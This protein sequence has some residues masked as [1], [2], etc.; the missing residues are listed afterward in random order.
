MKIVLCGGLGEAPKQVL[1]Y[2]S[3]REDVDELAVCTHKDNKYTTG[4]TYTCEYLKVWYTAESINTVAL[5]FMPDVIASVYYKH[6]IKGHVIDMVGGKIINAHAALLPRHRGRSA[7]PWAIIERDTFSGVTYHYIDPGID[8]GPIILQAAVL[9][10]K[11]ETQASLFEKV[12]AAVVGFFPAALELVQAGFAGVEQSEGGNYNRGGPPYDGQLS[13]EWPLNKIE[14][15]IRA[16][17]YPPYPPAQFNG[18]DI[19]TID[20]Y[21]K[22]LYERWRERKAR[23]HSIPV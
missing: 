20:D 2:L 11:Q 14:R 3:K 12:D 6:I 18:A 9:I 21:R 10:D 19:W 5:P 4:L 16:M 8:T 17:N 13:P 23:E 1:E 15:F 22:Q 7:I